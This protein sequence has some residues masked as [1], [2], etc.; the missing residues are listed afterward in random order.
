MTETQTPK[1]EATRP[2]LHA[3]PIDDVLCI[4][5]DSRIVHELTGGD[6]ADMMRAINRTVRDMLNHFARREWLAG[7]TDERPNW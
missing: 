7:R 1:H 3:Q 4:C 2:M 5:D 6:A